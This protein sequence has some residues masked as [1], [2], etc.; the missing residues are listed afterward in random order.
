VPQ[1]ERH[2]ALTLTPEVRAQVVGLS[3]ATIDRRL[4]PYRRTD[5]RR[6]Y[7]PSRAAGSLK[8]QIPL[9][10]FGNWHEVQPGAL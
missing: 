6:P 8:A 5:R 2:G 7:S 4:A 9:R 1:L 3:A 10:T